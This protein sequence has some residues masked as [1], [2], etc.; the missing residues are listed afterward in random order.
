MF[1]HRRAR[2][3][4]SEMIDHSPKKIRNPHF[5]DVLINIKSSNVET[6]FGKVKLAWIN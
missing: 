6:G 5:Y 1:F 3:E 4:Q 2:V